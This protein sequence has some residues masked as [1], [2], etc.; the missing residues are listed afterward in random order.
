MPEG[1]DCK[2][3]NLKEL[4]TP[5][6][7]VPLRDFVPLSARGL[8]ASKNE[9]Y[10][11]WITFH[12]GQSKAPRVTMNLKVHTDIKITCL[13]REDVRKLARLPCRSS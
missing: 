9:D 12:T 3:P 1:G 11:I 10:V 13:A 7:C 6:G 5:E 4:N 2:I 8:V